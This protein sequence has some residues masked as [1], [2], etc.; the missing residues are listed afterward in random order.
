[1]IHLL[2]ESNEGQCRVKREL[3]NVGGELDR[4][5][6]KQK[7]KKTPENSKYLLI[8]TLTV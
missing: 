7:K 3:F 1:M 6:R 2:V 5:M 8:I 4:E